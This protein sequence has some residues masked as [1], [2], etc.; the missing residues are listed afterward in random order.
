MLN[1]V[2][3]LEQ[4]LL[5]EGKAKRTVA[6]YVKWAKRLARWCELQGLDVAT[7]E[8]WQ[9]REWVDQTVPSSRESRKQ[10]FTA[11]S[12]LYR[13]LGRTDQPHLAIRVPHK[14]PGKPHPLTEDERIRLR[15]TAI[16]VGPRPGLATLGMLQTSC[17]PS[18]V[19][20]WRWDGVREDRIR[21][22]RIKVRD[23]HEVPLRPAL[24]EQLERARPAEAEG[25]IFQG[26]K[27][28]AHVHP[29]TI[30][31]WAREVGRI[32]GV[33]SVNPRRLRATA[34]TRVLETAGLDVAAELAGHRDPAVTKN[35]Y[36]VTSWARLE[37]GSVAL[38]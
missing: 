33:D 5:G 10:A 25:Y 26:D 21:F 11:L 9:V 24:A 12:H 6:E 13:M 20:M 29:N 31:E 27:G 14:R 34:V 23:W 15:D 36:A 37:S 4:M 17:R 3:D 22:W 35:Y 7:V 18:E 8:P 28:K 32:A 2:I 1:V 19:A 38:D 16:L 30:W